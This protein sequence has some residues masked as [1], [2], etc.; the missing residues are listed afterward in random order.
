MTAP[1]L[2]CWQ[3]GA[4]VPLPYYR[5]AA[6]QAFGEGEVRRLET[7]EERSQ[8][9]HNQWFAWVSDI[10]HHHLPESEHGRWTSPEDLRHWILTWTRFC[11]KD[12]FTYPTKAEADRARANFGKKYHRVDVRDKTFLGYTA[13]SQSRRAMSKRAFQ[14][15]KN[16]CAEQLAK[17][18]GVDVDVLR[19]EAAQK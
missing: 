4:W 10:Y 13:H 3:D 7:I 6:E 18:L 19:K 1:L 16:A 14:E 12:E 15:S 2:Y 9:S 17:L 11:D 8:A 5:K